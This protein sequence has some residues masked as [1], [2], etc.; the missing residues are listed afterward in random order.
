MPAGVFTFSR[1]TMK[2]YGIFL[3]LG[4]LL[5]A[6]FYLLIV[7]TVHDEALEK[8]EQ[9]ALALLDQAYFDLESEARWLQ[10]YEEIELRRHQSQLEN[11][12]QV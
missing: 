8:Q 9:S 3:V 10:Q 5:A 12:I 4:L 11:V 7:P 2:A 6:A 1:I